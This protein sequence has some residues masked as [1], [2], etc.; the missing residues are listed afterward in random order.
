MNYAYVLY[1]LPVSDERCFL[2]YK[3]IVSHCGSF[4]TNGYVYA[5]AGIV[6]A[7]T[8]EEAC[9][10]LFE[11]YNTMR[12]SDYFGRSMSVSDIIKLS[13]SDCP[14]A[15]EVWFCDSVGFKKLDSKPLDDSEPERFD[16]CVTFAI[17]GRF[18]VV[19]KA[20]DLEEAKSVAQCYFETEDFGPLEVV[21]SKLT[22]V[23]ND[24][25]YIVYEA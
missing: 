21:D 18:S 4:D 3:S 15:R 22:I 13:T 25:G 11:V 9:E 24:Q 12:P 16:Y 19:V 1:Q 5:D 20:P 23:E 2:N 6:E 8:P 10:K 7:D 17:D 14:F